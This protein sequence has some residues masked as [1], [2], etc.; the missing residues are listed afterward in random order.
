MIHCS[1]HKDVFEYTVSMT[2]KTDDKTQEAKDQ[3]LNMEYFRK[4]GELK[5]LLDWFDHKLKVN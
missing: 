3:K 4:S 1:T 5:K 2:Y